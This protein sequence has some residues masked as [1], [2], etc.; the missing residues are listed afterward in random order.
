MWI[1]FVNGLVVICVNQDYYLF[2]LG[3]KS[4]PET[5]R[6]M[7]GEQLEKLEDVYH[8]FECY[9]SGKKNKNGVKVPFD[10]CLKQSFYLFP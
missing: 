9:I 3:S 8:I 2:Y 6:V 7:W 5:R 1:V 10:V 4:K